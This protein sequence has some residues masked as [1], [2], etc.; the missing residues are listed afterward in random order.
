MRGLP[1]SSSGPE[2]HSEGIGRGWRLTECE[3]SL[4]W[5]AGPVES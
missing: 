2:T 5:T 3:E 4:L 1:S